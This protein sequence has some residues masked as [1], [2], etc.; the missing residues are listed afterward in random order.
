MKFNAVRSSSVM[1]TTVSQLRN[2]FSDRTGRYVDSP[3]RSRTT[4][5]SGMVSTEEGIAM[6]A[7]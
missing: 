4:L 1:S 6:I 7:E 2:P 3:M 5:I